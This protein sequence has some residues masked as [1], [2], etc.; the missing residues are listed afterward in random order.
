MKK[1]KPE[2]SPSHCECQR[3]AVR[4]G[5]PVRGAGT[6]SGGCERCLRMESS[7]VDYTREVTGFPEPVAG[8]YDDLSTPSCRLISA[9]CAAFL[10]RRGVPKTVWNTCA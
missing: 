3:P 7:R 4:A 1:R 2:R 6:F 8:K 5:Q 10:T 9:A